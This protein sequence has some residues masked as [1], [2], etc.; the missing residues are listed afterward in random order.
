M[1]LAA[2]GPKAVVWH[3]ID[4][5]KLFPVKGISAVVI[6]WVF[7][8]VF[9]G[10][11][12]ALFFWVARTF[13]LRAEN[14][15]QR[16]FMFLPVLLA[17]TV[18]INAFYVLDKGGVDKFW[19][20]LERKGIAA[21]AWISAIIAGV[22]LLGGFAYSANLKKKVEAGVENAAAEATAEKDVGVC[23]TVTWRY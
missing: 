17:I 4:T 18:F 7:S 2:H 14:S 21:S 15:V 23:C 8:P 19:G 13:I 16:T 3:A 9:S 12:A 11:V 22:S 5:S 1:G 6:S 10:I 20:Y